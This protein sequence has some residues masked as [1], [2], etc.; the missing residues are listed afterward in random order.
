MSL[1]ENKAIARRY[2]DAVNEQNVDALD[3]FIAADVVHHLFGISSLEGY[4]Q[5]VSTFITAF[6]DLNFT[7]DDQIA[8]GTR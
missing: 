3:E 6:P 5:T 8:E 4:K 2:F 1:E 7:I